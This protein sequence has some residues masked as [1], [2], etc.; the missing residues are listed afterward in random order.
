MEVVPAVRRL[1]L[2]FNGAAKGGFTLSLLERKRA[3][4]LHGVW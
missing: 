2:F 3:E 4:R 1:F